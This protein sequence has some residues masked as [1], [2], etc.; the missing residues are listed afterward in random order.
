MG[1]HAALGRVRGD[2]IEML[3]VGRIFEIAEGRHAMPLGA[4]LRLR[5]PHEERCQRPGA[6]DERLAAG[7]IAEADHWR[8]PILAAFSASHHHTVVNPEAPYFGRG[9]RAP[10]PT[11]ALATIR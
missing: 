6:D 8:G 2:I 5:R 7:R 10:K 3:E 1:E 4:L 11:P 9:S